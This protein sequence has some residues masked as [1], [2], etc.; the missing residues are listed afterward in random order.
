MYLPN[1]KPDTKYCLPAAQLVAMRWWSTLWI[2]SIG[3]ELIS[4]TCLGLYWWL[5]GQF[6]PR[7]AVTWGGATWIAARTAGMAIEW[8]LSLFIQTGAPLHR[9]IAYAV[10][11]IPGIGVIYLAWK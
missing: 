11:M 1:A 10:Q 3:I 8:R 5:S 7:L 2:A 9:W 6:N 4:Y